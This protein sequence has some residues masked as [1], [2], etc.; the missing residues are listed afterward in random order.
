MKTLKMCASTRKKVCYNFA[1]TLLCFDKYNMHHEV[2]HNAC[3]HTRTLSLSMKRMV[4][5]LHKPHTIHYMRIKLKHKKTLV[6]LKNIFVASNCRPKSNKW[7]M[8]HKQPGAT[9][10]ACMLLAS[11]TLLK[12]S[13]VINQHKH[14][15][16]LTNTSW[17][18]YDTNQGA[19]ECTGAW[20][21]GTRMYTGYLFPNINSKL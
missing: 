8:N 9:P 18:H 17:C 4:H 11:C 1:I 5:K 19:R 15:H 21:Q 7:S 20:T 14:K 16:A 13:K 3:F 10:H 2:R 6:I 12:P